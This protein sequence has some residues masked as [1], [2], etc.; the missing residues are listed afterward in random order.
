MA[1]SSQL[2]SNL[3]I[4]CGS[5]K[6]GIRRVWLAPWQDS[7]KD[8][9]RV[10]YMTV[11]NYSEEGEGKNIP[12]FISNVSGLSADW[13]EFAFKP[14]TSQF[15]T[16]FNRD[17]ANGT[18]YY[19]TEISMTFRKMETQK[20]LAIASLAL[21]DVYVVVE[22]CNGNYWGFGTDGEGAHLSANT[23]QTG[24]NKTDSNAYNITLS[25]DSDSLP[26]QLDEAAVE[27]FPGLKLIE[28]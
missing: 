27:N 3:E 18:Q 24:T 20:R 23:G 10:P 2:I 15:T 14:N 17:D 19:T 22:D 9:T 28:A 12:Y 8:D 11:Q 4:E 13:K 26:L 1:C 21:A 6:G 7:V 16:T 5:N 25:V